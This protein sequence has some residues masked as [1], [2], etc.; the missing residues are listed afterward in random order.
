AGE[1]DDEK[2]ET[3][4]K[5]WVT[6]LRKGQQTSDMDLKVLTVADDTQAGYL[7]PAEVSR[8]VIRDITEFSPIRQYASVRETLAPSVKYPVRTGLTN[9]KW[10]GEIEEAEE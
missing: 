10:E 6:Y 3:E 5:A 7:A 9:A 8:D 2:S 1:G 4:L